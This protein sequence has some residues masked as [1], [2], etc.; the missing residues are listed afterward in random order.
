MADFF[1]WTQPVARVAH[2]CSVCSRTISK[3]ETYAHCK[4][5]IDGR[6]HVWREC[7]H[8]NAMIE[9]YGIDDL[10][11]NRPGP[12][13]VED[14]EF[15]TITGLRHRAQFKKRWQRADG[16]LLDVPGTSVH[17]ASATNH[18]EQS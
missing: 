16:T 7:A 5:F 13:S 2:R 17:M 18:K 10:D 1:V 4:G 11:G 12:D 8:C 6:F 15:T 9:S 14:F 3:G